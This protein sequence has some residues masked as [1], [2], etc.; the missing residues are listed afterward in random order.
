M[1]SHPSQ[2]SSSTYMYKRKVVAR[3]P[4]VK[5]ASKTQYSFYKLD[6]RARKTHL[7]FSLLN[8]IYT[9]VDTTRGCLQT[10]FVI[11]SR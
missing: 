4:F 2:G 8:K 5:F 11:S 7:L 10:K 3:I 6:L 1:T 9:Y